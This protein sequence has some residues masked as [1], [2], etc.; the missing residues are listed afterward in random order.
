MIS[1][2]NYQ[3]SEII[4]QNDRVLVSRGKRLADQKP[5]VVKL[6]K[7]EYP[8]IEDL[9]RFKQEYEINNYL[10]I[11]GII[12]VYSLEKYNHSLILVMEDYQGQPLFNLI[13]KI[14]V[15]TALE[16]AITIND[17]LGKIHQKNVIHK[18][19]TPFNILFNH[20][21][22]IK[23]IDFGIST[24]LS[25]EKT[26]IAHNSKLEGTLAY[27]SPE[28]TGRMNRSVDYR[29][30]FY[31]L[32]IMLY[33]LLTGKLPFQAE[34]SLELIHQHIAKQPVLPHQLNT[35]IP[36]MLSAIILKL[37]AKTAEG[38]Y[39][40]SYGLHQDLQYCL[41]QLQNTQIIPEFILAQYDISDKLHISQ[42][43]YGRETEVSALMQA[44][45]RVAQ[46]ATELMLVVG[47]AGIGKSVLINEIHKPIVATSGYFI[48]GKFDQLQNGTPYATITQ[49]L[50]GLI[51][52]L[53]SEDEHAI[54][55]WKDK[56]LGVL[57]VNAQLMVDV[58]PYLS[59]LI[60]EQ[61]A[62][63]VLP[64]LEAKNRFNLVL[65]NF[66]QVFA[67]QTHPLVIFFDD[68][69][70][71][72]SET[73]YLM[74]ALVSNPETHHL[75]LISAYRDNEVDNNHP[76][77]LMLNELRKEAVTLNQ[78]TLNPLN[79]ADISA[80]LRDSLHCDIAT[81]QPLAQLLLEK[82]AG[83]PFFV[84]ESLEA[85]Y[86]KSY[87]SFN[88]TQGCWQWD[89]QTLAN[90]AL[91]SNVVE[92][93][94]STIRELAVETQ[95]L[96]MIAA[97]L[98]NTFNLKMLAAIHAAPARNTAKALWQSLEQGLVL[99][100]TDAYKSTNQAVL[101]DKQCE[102]I[103]YRFLHDR[104]QQAAYSLI[105]LEQKPQI[106][107]KIARVLLNNTPPQDL[108]AVIFDIVNALN[109][110]AELL[111]TEAEIQELI[112]LNFRAAK[113]AKTANAYEFALKYFISIAKNL[114]K[115]AWE[116]DYCFM[117]VLYQ[118]WSECE[119][120]SSHVEQAETLLAA[121]LFHARTEREK[122]EIYIRWIELY[123][124]QGRFAE[125]VTLGR[126]ALALQH[127]PI[128]LEDAALQ[129]AVQIQSQ[130][131]Q[132]YLQGRSIEHLLD[133]NLLTDAEQQ[134]TLR[135]LI[136]LFSPA[137]NT[138]PSLVQ[139]VT[140]NMVQISLHHGHDKNSAYAYAIYGMLFGQ[141]LNNYQLGYEFGQLGIKLSEQF[142]S[143]EIQAKVY[144]IY[145]GFI[146]F[147]KQSLLSNLPYLKKA[148]TIGLASGDMVYTG[149]AAYQCIAQS[150]FRGEP[151][152]KL[153]E[154][155]RPYLNFL[156]RT[157][158]Q[159]MLEV[160]KPIHHLILNLHSAEYE[161]NSL[162]NNGFN[163]QIALESLKQ[164]GYFFGLVHFYTVQIQFSYLYERH[165]VGLSFMHAAQ[166]IQ[167]MFDALSLAIITE[168]YFYAALTV[169]ALYESAED[170]NKLE[171]QVFLENS[172][173]KM[174][175]WAQNSPE[176]YQ[177]K[178]LLLAAELAR[179]Q[180]QYWEA[181]NL[182][183]QAIDCLPSDEFIQ[184]LAVI[185]EV[186]A[187]FYSKQGRI[188]TAKK[189]FTEASYL[190]LKWGAHNKV[191]DLD[192]KYGGAFAMQTENRHFYTTT[193][194]SNTTTTHLPST[195]SRIGTSK[196]LDLLSIVKASQALSGE[197]ELSYLLEK[198]MRF[199][200]ENAGAEKGF[201]LL[202]Q[203]GQWFIKAAG[204][205]NNTQVE[206]VQTH[207]AIEP[208]QLANTL[209]HYVARTQESVVLNNASLEG[210]F[211]RDPYVLAQHPKSILCTPIRHQA[212]LVGLL[213]LE[214]NL[215]ENSFTPA[216]LEVLNIL[217]SQIAISIQNAQLYAEV[218][219]SERTLT[220]FLD[221]LP[222]GIGILDKQGL[223][224]FTN[225]RATELLGQGVVKGTP[226]NQLC[227]T[228]RLCLAGTEQTYPSERLP[229]LRAL[230][231]EQSSVDDIEVNK[232]GGI[233]PI[234]SWGCPIYDEKGQIIYAMT[235]FQDISERKQ[236]EENRIC[237]VQEQEAK[238]VALRYSAEIQAQNTVLENTLQQ[239]RNTQQQLI[240]AEK[241]SALGNLVA[242]VAHE[243]NT[244]VGIGVTAATQLD[245]LTIEFANLYK[246]GKMGRADLEQY[247]N[248]THQTSGL[249][250]KNLTRAAQLTQSF[251]QV[252]VDQASEQQRS[253]VLYDY[254]NEIL[255]SL[256]P[257]L[258]NTGY[259]VQIECDKQISL[260]T[261]PGAFSQIITNLV[262]NSMIHGFQGRS[263]GHIIIQVTEETT[264]L[265]L[266]YQ[267][268]GVG[269]AANIID[270][271]F[272]PFFT[273]NRQEG[274]T[275]LGLHIVYNLVTHHLNGTIR[276]ES[277]YGKGVKFIL[278]IP[279]NMP[280]N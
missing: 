75:L 196:A 218:K 231:G 153:L 26:D 97:C 159:G 2:T 3:L 215:A 157:K 209:I 78:I 136:S 234:E 255:I 46:G 204:Q 244:P 252:A 261:Y 53:L 135:L 87:L 134:L 132:Q 81:A 181:S 221:A 103:V 141:I 69:Q 192:E 121:Y 10:N 259:Q 113:T 120:L 186:A 251:K 151:L 131:V 170:S 102:K 162:N 224:Y 145:S 117:A 31:S 127:L 56:I 60:G 16:I 99:P 208:E 229:I 191:R 158:N 139:W 35:A 243:I 137:L 126:D 36:P 15:R 73:L 198:M 1:L 180:Q 222:V 128:P 168:Y 233:I 280:I 114:H 276:C 152:A 279:K 33:Q 219:E 17:I 85:L 8:S 83:N 58:I 106:H 189:Y 84:N 11:E 111:S 179:I 177:H 28:Q 237:L 6:L 50:Q 175:V 236:A 29:S 18:D 119:F 55:Q 122:V 24:R 91:S 277:E 239:L 116:N 246:S 228:Y 82:T 30:D 206:I 205:L 278:H 216:R 165:E 223:P 115:N 264:Q 123:T 4:Y 171:Y 112:Q 257:K 61:A 49:A 59:L 77:S 45:Q 22:Q 89:N 147:W 226:T 144:H 7:A 65:Q 260:M 193:T 20:D 225:R 182:Y 80:L 207:R 166:E 199:V 235:A 108:D 164:Q 210:N 19:I 32:G 66:I 57:G 51:Q 71:I 184:N 64:A 195:K 101:E 245:S 212:R 150:F 161:P 70:W 143:S 214:N 125:A 148:Y 194:S 156:Q 213:Y 149:F 167:F 124:T 240:E 130:A 100:I 74:H 270:K 160:I 48:S 183:E 173:R 79:L 253:I 249:I 250:L 202:P 227:A 262:I 140:L 272:E 93:M 197:I 174:Q 63:E 42:K 273:T 90:M 34:D 267:D 43:L 133:A 62:V 98:G 217:S 172:L 9:T 200:L 110:G 220:Q 12:R 105:P 37:M 96:L 169:A 187:R 268:D 254:L 155:N 178:A 258:K 92:L 263:Q 52:Q 86:K 232:V 190:Y 275:G 5:V 265:R 230:Q 38:R 76:L 241:M 188:R 72:D 146:H 21:Y 107:L 25:Q 68:L 44:F 27:L 67:Q 238:N 185:S 138:N 203:Q 201:F 247:L 242:G 13:G 176:N 40:S 154:D 109:L 266:D 129:Q 118:E 248:A 23:I 104:I 94:V 163:A 256:K 88:P 54:N 39:Q 274:G 41:T 142:K 211:T 269:I 271:I 14:S 47:Q 95:E